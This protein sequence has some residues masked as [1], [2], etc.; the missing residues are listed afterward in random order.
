M[1]RSERVNKNNYGTNN[2][3]YTMN[4]VAC[5][6]EGEPAHNLEDVMRAVDKTLKNEWWNLNRNK[7]TVLT[8]R[9]VPEIWRFVK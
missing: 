1:I 4:N 7:I 2:N 3:N 9:L 6:S 5:M 8:S